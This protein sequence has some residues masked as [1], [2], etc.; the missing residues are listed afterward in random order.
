MK[1]VDILINSAIYAFYM[2]LSCIA[3]MVLE[4][5]IVEL[6]ICK[7]LGTYFPFSTLTLA[8]IRAIIYTVGVN[9]L[10]GIMLYKDGYRSAVSSMPATLVSGLI[11]SVLHFFF[12]LLFGFEAFCAGGVKFISAIYLFGSSLSSAE[13]SGTLER[14]DCIPFFFINSVIY[15]AVMILA[16]WLGA[17][18]R[19][20]DRAE[21]TRNKQV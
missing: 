19:L 20:S 11:A 8:T 4:M 2:L 12:S 16:Q 21:L 10:L 13:F 9:V 15:I 14:I 1:K 5:L 7:I 6:F 3:I 17:K 18:N